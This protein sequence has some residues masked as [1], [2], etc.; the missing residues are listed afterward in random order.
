MNQHVSFKM[1]KISQPDNIMCFWA[2]SVS[3][4]MDIRGV[5]VSYLGTFVR[6]N[7][8]CLT[9]RTTSQVCSELIKSHTASEKI[10]YIDLVLRS[11]KTSCV[12]QAIRF[13]SHAWSCNFLAVVETL[14]Q[15]CKDEKEDESTC[16][17]WFDIFS[18]NQHSGIEDFGHWS[19]SF[20]SAI[21]KIGRAWI[22]FIPFLP[23]WLERSWCLFELYAMVEGG[24]PFE[25]LLPSAEE[26]EFTKYLIGGGKVEDAISKID[27]RKATAFKQSD[28][29]NI[30]QIVAASMGH[31]KLNE[32][33]T[34]EMRKWFVTCAEWALGRMQND[35]KW[36]CVLHL[37]TV[38][39]YIT[40]GRLADADLELETRHQR[41]LA[42][43]DA[44]PLN[45][46]ETLCE[47]GTVKWKLGQ[48]DT[49]LSLLTEARVMCEKSAAENLELLG[50]V[51]NRIGTVLEAQGKYQ[52]AISVY[53]ESLDIKIR[54]F[55]SHNHVNV[56][57][58]EKNI[59][60]VLFRKGEY[61]NALLRYQKA[62]AIEEQCLGTVHA[63][64]ATTKKNIG[65]VHGEMGDQITAKAYYKEAYDIYLRS[66]GPDHPYTKELAAFI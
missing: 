63:S 31:A 66:L 34:T 48:L 19:E 6:E 27:I 26:D 16:F 18:V 54:Y 43:L 55:G 64:V 30:N 50:N 60:N 14:V 24:V 10:S 28:K 38:K 37:N 8:M 36:V 42:L 46:A 61:E 5:S 41:Q 39:M 35:E 25:I 11:G 62:L 15:K 52:E 4:A 32:L 23:V 56:A 47:L 13:V 3:N 17:V 57:A 29:D 65:I 2:D 9:G 12:G 20:Q 40:L 21:R 49:A 45:M 53:Q 58:T 1:Y 22:I 33:V 44:D 7:A 51:T 59:G